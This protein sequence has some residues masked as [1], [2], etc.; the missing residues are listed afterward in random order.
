[1]LLGDIISRLD[2]EAMAMQTLVGLGDLVLLTQVE[3]AAAAEG[4]TAGGFAARAVNLFSNQASDEDWVSLI[5]VMG[6][7]TDP[8]QACLR[9]IL[10]FALRPPREAVH[11][12]GHGH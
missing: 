3:T 10:H 2:D 11:A 12:C 9:N 1:M 5:G 8:G 7:T 6:R 4:L